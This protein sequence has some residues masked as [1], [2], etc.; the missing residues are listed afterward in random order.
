MFQETVIFIISLVS[1]EHLYVN[2]VQTVKDAYFN[3]RI[4]LLKFFQQSFYFLALGEIFI[5]GTLLRK[6]AGTLDEFQTVIAAPGDDV[7]LM[8]TV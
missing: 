1:R 8:H 4:V 6:A 3:V 2:F 5:M 7:I